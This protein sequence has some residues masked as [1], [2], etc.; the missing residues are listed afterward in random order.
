MALLYLA[1]V[2]IPLTSSFVR[3]VGISDCR[4]QGRKILGQTTSCITSIPN[5]TQIRPAVLELDH[6]DRQTS[7]VY[8]RLTHNVQ[9][10]DKK[11]NR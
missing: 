4:N 11:L 7:H 5:F 10:M 1:S 3:H 8:V 6:V 9:R 2:S